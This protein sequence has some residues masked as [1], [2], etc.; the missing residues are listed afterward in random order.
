MSY[1]KYFLI[2]I[3]LFV[4]IK[5]YSQQKSGYYLN[6]NSDHTNRIVKPTI[7]LNDDEAKL[8]NC[9][10]VT[11]D[12]DKRLKTVEYFVSGKKS[13]SSNFGAHILERKYYTNHYEEIFKNE[14]QERVTNKNGVWFHKYQL[15][16]AGFWI[17]KENYDNNGKLLNQYGVAVYKV[18][19]DYQNR[20]LT[21]I[22]YNLNTDT[23]PDPNGF[24]VTHFTYNKDGFIS[25][26]Q[27]RNLDGELENGKYGYAKVIF[28]MDQN[29]QFYG[30]EFIDRLGNLVNSSSLGYAKIDMRDFNKYGKNKRFYFT[31]ESGYPSK[32]KAMGVI[33][34]HDNMSRN[35]I[36]YFDRYG[37]QTKDIN[38]RARSKYI[39]DKNG[40]FI[41]R[42]NYN[43][44][45]RPIK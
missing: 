29:G 18:N 12:K 3:T 44:E 23:I 11:F 24:K 34:Y 31:D 20:R 32:E 4:S 21:E 41:K 39:Y 1:K 26:R 35:E 43:F 37:N 40:E 8:I 17:K 6:W 36:I 30:E 38:E 13:S 28:H 5:T 22:R 42:V 14:K 25:S 19:R 15:N 7:K 9:Y 2:V 33:T 45:G 16:E 27:N 10:K